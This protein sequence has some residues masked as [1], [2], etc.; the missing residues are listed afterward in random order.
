MEARCV[1]KNHETSNLSLPLPVQVL[2]APAE[3]ETEKAGGE[4]EAATTASKAPLLPLAAHVPVIATKATSGRRKRQRRSGV[5]LRRPNDD[6][7][8]DAEGD[9][10]M[11]VEVGKCRGRNDACVGCE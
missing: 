3:E 11:N 4:G 1:L 6:D 7:E 2:V 5:F 10:V 8:E 9:K